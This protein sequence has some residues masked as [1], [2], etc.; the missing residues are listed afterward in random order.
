VW[1]RKPGIADFYNG[2]LLLPERVSREAFL[3]QPERVPRGA[4]SRVEGEVEWAPPVL[5]AS[6]AFGFR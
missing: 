3:F 1:Q 4:L 6:G 5:G 2:D